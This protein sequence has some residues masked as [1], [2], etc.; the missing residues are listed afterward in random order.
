[1]L[2]QFS[3]V[4]W[5]NARYMAGAGLT[6]VPFPCATGK[7]LGVL[8]RWMALDLYVTQER[9]EIRGE[10]GSARRMSLTTVGLV[11]NKE[12]QALNA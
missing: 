12:G 4:G 11:Q 7:D 1:V 9:R 2:N 5:L 3:N 6:P 10:L 8:K